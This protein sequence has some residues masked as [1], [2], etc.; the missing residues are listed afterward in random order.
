M[1]GRAAHKV[2]T[3]F[4]KLYGRE[5]Y[6][7]DVAGCAVSNNTPLPLNM[8][9]NPGGMVIMRKTIFLITLFVFLFGATG[10]LFAEEL[11]LGLVQSRIKKGMS[12]GEVAQAI[13]SP[14]IA[15]N[16]RNGNETWIYDKISSETET[17]SENEGKSKSSGFGVGGGGSVGGS[18]GFLGVGGGSQKNEV[19][20]KETSK[21]KSTKKT[22]TVIIKFDKKSLVKHMT[23]H[24]SQF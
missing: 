10:A 5:L 12:Q 3:V 22:L 21:V 18:G 7:G 4:I 8:N 15:S 24:M 19:S 6:N 1:I 2:F 23:Y 9:G 13:G 16:D 17:V 11:T 20:R 14:N